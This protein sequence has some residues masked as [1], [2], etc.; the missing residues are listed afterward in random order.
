MGV[1]KATDQLS[2]GRWY[3]AAGQWNGDVSRPGDQVMRG[4][5]GDAGFYSFVPGH[6]NVPFD[7]LE[8]WQPELGRLYLISPIGDETRSAYLPY[9]V[10]R[11]SG[12]TSMIVGELDDDFPEL[13]AYVMVSGSDMQKDAADFLRPDDP[14]RDYVIYVVGALLVAVAAG[15]AVYYFTRKG[16]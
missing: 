9:N 4:R 6:T 3:V 15:V 7:V 16:G 5:F 2:P 12:A 11:T 13:L 14:R 10:L 1:F 8:G